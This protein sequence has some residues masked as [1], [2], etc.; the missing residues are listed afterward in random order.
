MLATRK[1]LRRHVLVIV[2]L[3]SLY[4]RSVSTPT[5]KYCT[6]IYRKIVPHVSLEN[7]SIKTDHHPSS[8]LEYYKST[9][10]FGIEG[11]DEE[12]TISLR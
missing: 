9:L 8:E 7:Q 3:D 12:P 4:C 1:H 2:F 5:T 11:F 10:L 6:L